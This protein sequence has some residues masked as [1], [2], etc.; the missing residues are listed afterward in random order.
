M[1][2]VGPVVGGRPE[3]EF[4]AFEEVLAPWAEQGG[5]AEVEVGPLEDVVTICLVLGHTRVVGEI[6]GAFPGKA[7]ERGDF[8]SVTAPFLTSSVA[9]CQPRIR[10][11]RFSGSVAPERLSAAA[12]V[13]KSLRL[14][15]GGSWTQRVTARRPP[16]ASRRR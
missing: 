6:E 16:G 7:P 5:R 11:S 4:V 10:I 1:E 2:E 14:S 15:R 9:V 8:P 13:A 12:A 3:V